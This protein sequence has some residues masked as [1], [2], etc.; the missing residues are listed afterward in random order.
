MALYSP[1][2][3]F[4]G[5]LTKLESGDLVEFNP[6]NQTAQFSRNGE[7]M[8][9]NFSGSLGLITNKVII[10]PSLEIAQNIA[11]LIAALNGLKVIISGNRFKFMK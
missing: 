6:E 9:F 11:V 10:G 7:L 8:L 1:T 2:L 4:Q 5:K 3:R